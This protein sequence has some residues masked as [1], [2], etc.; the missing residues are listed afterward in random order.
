MD[1]YAVQRAA[2]VA[3]LLF[4]TACFSYVPV[5][6]QVVPPGENVRVYLTRVGMAN[7]G[8]GLPLDLGAGLSGTLVQQQADRLLLRVPIAVRQEGFHLAPIAQDLW[9]PAGEILQFERRRFDPVRTGLL[10][11]GGAGLAGTV[12]ATIISNSQ[13]PPDGGPP[14]IEDLRIPLLSFPFP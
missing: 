5:E 1:R 12:I 11:A 7:L 13:G 14:I 9:I 2:T 4:L 10:V 8:D 3:A 6:P